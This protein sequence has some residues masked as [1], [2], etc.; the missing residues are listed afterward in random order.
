MVSGLET[1]IV[2]AIKCHLKFQFSIAGLNLIIQNAQQWWYIQVPHTK[3]CPLGYS[4][5]YE[6]GNRILVI[7]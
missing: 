5:V 1:Q 2:T 4:F 6:N 7:I 3:N